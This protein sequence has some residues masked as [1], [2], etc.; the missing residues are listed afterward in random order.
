MKYGLKMSD[1][2][3]WKQPKEETPSEN[4]GKSHIL[5]QQA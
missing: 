1:R 5:P 3:K 2:I 4:N